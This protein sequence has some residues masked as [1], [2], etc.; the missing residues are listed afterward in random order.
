MEGTNRFPFSLFDVRR[1]DGSSMEE[2]TAGL[3]SKTSPLYGRLKSMVCAL[4]LGTLL[5]AQPIVPSKAGML[6][7]GE[8][9]IYIDD[10]VM[11]VPLAQSLVVGENSVLHTGIG[12]AEVLLG[13]CA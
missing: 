5:S 12:G 13:P 1:Y 7:Y 2:K 4:A 6:T 8:G 3:R 10:R 11:A 9:Q